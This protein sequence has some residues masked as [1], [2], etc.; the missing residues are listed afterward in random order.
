MGRTVAG[1]VLASAAVAFVLATGAAS[2]LPPRS[3]SPPPPP[4]GGGGSPV[5]V[6]R[7][8]A[9]GEW[10]VTDTSATH[11][12]SPLPQDTLKSTDLPDSWDWR[13]SR[14]GMNLC[15]HVLTQQAPHVCGSCWAEAA[16]GALSDRFKIATRGQLN[17]QLAPQNLLNFAPALTGGGCQGGDSAKA[18]S[19]IQR[20]GITDDTCTTF[21]GEDFGNN[22]GFGDPTS[23][24]LL[25]AFVRGRMCHYC[26]WNGDCD[27]LPTRSVSAPAATPNVTVGGGVGIAKTYSVDEFGKVAGEQN[28]MKE[29]YA[30]GPVACY[31]ESGKMVFNDYVGGVIQYPHEVNTTDHVIVI[32]GWGRTEEGLDYWIGRNSY[33]TR[34]GEGVGGGWFRLQRGNNTLN[35][36]RAGCA[37]ATPSAQDVAALMNNT[38]Y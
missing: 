38:S 8:P 25:Q 2:P 6:Q 19:F 36:E 10:D 23:E 5:G 4:G 9:N 35:M 13:S 3:S 20:F 26:E 18:Y 11:V 37:W 15:T 7:F 14:D 1:A 21:L 16:T 32:A 22:F 29:V 28:I 34:W 24:K 30:R 12:T 17:L 31:L 27:W 33:G